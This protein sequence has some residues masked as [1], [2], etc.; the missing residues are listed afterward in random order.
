M[1]LAALIA[2]IPLAACGGGGGTP[3]VTVASVAITAPAA[4][5]SFSTLGRTAQFT[6]QAK[7]A[8]GA[9][10][11]GASISWSSSNSGVATVSGSGL[12]TATGNGTSQINATSGG[13][14]SGPVTVTVAQVVAGITITPGSVAF[15]ALG[16]T[17]QLSAAVTDSGGAVVPGMTPPQFTHAGGSAASVSPGGLVTALAPGNT[18]TAVVGTARAPISV[19]QVPAS[20]TVTSTSALPDTLFA[21]G[22]TRQFSAAVADSNGNAIGSASLTWSSTAGG[23][24][25]VNASSGLVTAVADGSANILATAGSK[26]GSRQVT[27]RR[28]AAT[29]SISPASASI[30]VNLDTVSFTGTAVDSSGTSLPLIWL[31]R[32]TS[33]VSM[34]PGTGPTSTARASGFNGSTSVVLLVASG[35][36]DS[37]AVTTSNQ[38]APPA[39]FAANVQPIFSASCAKVGCHTG[40][41]PQAGMNLTAGSAYAAIVNIVA[42]S[43]P[44]FKRVNPGDPN[45]SYIVMKL[46]GDPR[47]QGNRMPD[48]GLF[49][50]PAQVQVIRTWI[51][52]GALNN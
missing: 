24:A 30:T 8:A 38:T 12:V 48:D 43:A 14:Q 40:T 25:G 28:L 41:V 52:Q 1:R 26:S 51:L 44:S 4:A 29:H 21:T 13:Q 16:S 19:V 37:A 2:F 18:D 23:V 9:V 6:A 42:N 47:I 32:N 10:I 31:S 17:R 34:N 35:P 15:G 50:T 33:I 22:R 39:S 20:V 27:V 45:N 5:P 7:D 3:P 49:L 11:G 46:E 36:V